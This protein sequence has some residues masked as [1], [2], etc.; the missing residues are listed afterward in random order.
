MTSKMKRF[1][2]EGLV[3]GRPGRFPCIAIQGHVFTVD[4]G[5]IRTVRMADEWHD[6]LQDVH[7]V[8]TVLRSDPRKNGDILTFRQ[9]PPDVYARHPF[10]H[11]REFLGG[12]P[13]DNYR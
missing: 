8:I 6:D 12:P 13:R 11:V 5:L 2:G 10:V 7:A 9:R 3:N 4:G 1:V